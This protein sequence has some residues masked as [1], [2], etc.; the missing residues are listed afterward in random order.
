M[1]PF[2]ELQ[3]RTLTSHHPTP[4]AL[5]SAFIKGKLVCVPRQ[6]HLSW[7]HCAPPS[8]TI[9]FPIGLLC[10]DSDARSAHHV[11]RKQRALHEAA[12][13]RP[14]DAGEVPQRCVSP[15]PSTCCTCCQPGTQKLQQSAQANDS[16]PTGQL[17]R[18]AVIG[19][20]EA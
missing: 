2:S 6:P 15:K 8:I 1:K 11:S 4:L 14:A 10:D 5:Q 16:H 19:G 3:S 12:H 9:A 7:I 20:S 13:D 17:G 18:V